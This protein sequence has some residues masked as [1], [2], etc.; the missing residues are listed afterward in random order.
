MDGSYQLFDGKVIMRI[1]RRICDTPED[2]L[3]SKFFFDIL[4]SFVGQLSEQKSRL[5]HIFPNPEKITTGDLRMFIQTMRYLTKIKAGVVPQVLKGSESF[6]EDRNLLNDFVEQFYNHW[7]HLHRFII[8]DSIGDRFD[9]RPYRTFN[10]I[11]ESLM[12]LIR[13]MYRD[14]QENITGTHPRIYRQVSAGAEIAAIA[15]PRNIHY[16]TALYRKLNTISVTSQVLLYP[17]MIFNSPM[18]KRNGVFTRVD[19]NPLKMIEI[20]PQNWLCYPAKVGT[21]LVMIYFSLDFFE[22]GF[23][24][25]NLFELATE[26]DLKR[27]PDAVLLYGIPPESTMNV[28]GCE[29][30]FYDD[31]ENDMLIG[32]IPCRDE[33]AYFGYLKKLALTLHNIKMLKQGRLPFHGAM[34]RIYLKGA[35]PTTFLVVGDTGAGKSETIEALRGLAKKEIEDMVIIADD[36]GS[37]NFGENGEILGYGTEMGAFVR[38]DDLQA[39]YALGQIDRTIIMNPDQIN[40]RVVLPVTKYDEVIKGYSLDFVLYANN[41]QVVDSDHPAIHKFTELEEALNVFRAGTVMSK[42]TTTTTGLVSAFYANVFGPVQYPDLHEAQAGRY[43]SE[44]FRQNVFVGELRTQLAIPGMERKGPELAARELLKY[45]R[46]R[47]HKSE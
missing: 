31:T 26:E 43:Y 39:G 16:P 33:F 1:T 28:A 18:N 4:K 7:R 17:P 42:G 8:C 24:L 45:I 44:M 11:V 29:T 36:M 6:I 40:A 12:H 47:K 34:F 41:Y 9:R 20:H 19:D 25:C 5:L 15:R 38:L 35:E 10:D 30:I 2:L 3:N 32:A 46:D 23:S 37:L 22:L 14:I 21:L 13:G 27:K